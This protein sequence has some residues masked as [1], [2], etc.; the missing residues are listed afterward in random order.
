MTTGDATSGTTPDAPPE[1][2]I[3]TARA[4]IGAIAWGEHHRIWELLAEEGRVTVLR[5]AATRGM[6]QQ[7]ATRLRDGAATA[8]EQE[9]FLA[10]LLNGLRADL[11]GNDLDALE[12][13]VD[14]EEG[15][16]GRAR[17]AMVAPLPEPLAVG[18]GLPVGT[19][20]LVQE[21]GGWRVERLVPQ[22]TR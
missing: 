15:G 18:G 14:D 20:E 9:E 4:F 7:L 13:S 2:V 3:D 6:D 21:G 5:V 17:V 8:A 22:A 16:P 10:D 19:L 1:E 11:A 12:Y